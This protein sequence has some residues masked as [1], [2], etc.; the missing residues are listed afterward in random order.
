M[1]TPDNWVILKITIKKETL[2]KILAGWSGGTL[3]EMLGE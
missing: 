3:M 1:Y 2:Y